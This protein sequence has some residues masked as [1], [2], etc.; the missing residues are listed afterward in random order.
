MSINRL[1]IALATASLACSANSLPDWDPR[2]TGPEAQ[3][4][5][6]GIVL[7]ED[8]TSRAALLYEHGAKAACAYGQLKRTLKRIEGERRT[9]VRVTRLLRTS[10]DSLNCRGPRALG[11]I[12]FD[13]PRHPAR[14]E[15]GE[16]ILDARPDLFFISAMS[17]WN[18]GY[19]MDQLNV[20]QIPS[21]GWH[22]LRLSPWGRTHQAP[23]PPVT[24][25]AEG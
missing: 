12:W 10:R 24:E 20:A 18:W 15:Q 2:A 5:L 3:V 4:D 17:G 14:L 21:D 9:Y 22:A 1:M 16:A 11:M 8:A 19:A 7:T 25:E 6:P 23:L 13:S